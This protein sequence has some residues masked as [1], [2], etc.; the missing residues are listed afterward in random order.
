MILYKISIVLAVTATQE[1][2]VPVAGY[3]TYKEVQEVKPDYKQL[4]P[5]SK[6]RIEKMSSYEIQSR[7]V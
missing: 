4:H 1:E 3:L 2:I 5:K 6:V 7:K